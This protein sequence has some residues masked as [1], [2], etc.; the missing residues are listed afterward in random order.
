MLGIHEFTAEK[1]YLKVLDLAADAPINFGFFGARLRLPGV[2]P[3]DRILYFYDCLT[4]VTKSS[5]L[6]ML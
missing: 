1:T 3:I 4:I 2:L 6:S 5:T